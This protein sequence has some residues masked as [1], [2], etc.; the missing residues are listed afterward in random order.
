MCN[1]QNPMW[2]NERKEALHTIFEN[3][4]NDCSIEK[5]NGTFIMRFAILL[6][7]LIL[8]FVND[9]SF[10]CSWMDRVLDLFN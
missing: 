6:S 9:S 7:I 1:G 3:K 2:N 10:N 4:S 5:Q 8:I